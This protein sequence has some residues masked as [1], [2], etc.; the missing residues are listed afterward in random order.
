MHTEGL[1]SLRNEE[2]YTSEIM[3]NDDIKSQIWYNLVPHEDTI[4]ECW[5]K[6]QVEIRKLGAVC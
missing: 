1:E 3:W 6:L 2:G 5:Y 4:K